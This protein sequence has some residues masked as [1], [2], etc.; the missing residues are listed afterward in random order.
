M[1]NETRWNSWYKIIL[2]ALELRAA[3]GKYQE[4][5]INEF[6]EED[7]LNATDWKA[8]E[9]IRDFLQPFKRVIKETEGDYITLNKVLYT[10]DFIVEHFKISLEKYATNP[11]LCD[12][13]RISWH[14]FDKY[15]L[16][17]DEVTAYSAA[18]LLAPHWRMNY[19]TC[20][21]KAS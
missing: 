11:K 17:T 14:A 18:L 3:I 16:K 9:S 10:I 6:N 1:D 8:L 2:V 13:I 19:I 20:N 15:Y 5:Y 4:E 21:W 7:I 12:C